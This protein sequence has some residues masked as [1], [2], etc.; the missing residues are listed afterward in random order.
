MSPNNLAY[1]VRDVATLALASQYPATSVAF[2]QVFAAKH[3]QICDGGI[4]RLIRRGASS[5]N[6][7][8]SLRGSGVTATKILWGQISFV[9]LIVLGAMWG[10]TQW[11]AW[12]LGFQPQLGP[13]WLELFG[14]PVYLPPA[15][16]WWWYRYDAYAPAIFLEGGLIAASG[17]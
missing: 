12:R 5:T 7:P 11:T 1:Q 2:R 15:L 16:F 3:I 13:P 6:H 9:F 4:S 8:L 10:A 17:G 14:V